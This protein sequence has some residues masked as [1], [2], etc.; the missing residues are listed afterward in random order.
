MTTSAGSDVRAFLAIEL[1]Q[2]ALVRVG[3]VQQIVRDAL[4]D[5]AYVR[6]NMVHI[7]LKFLGNVPATLVPEIERLAAPAVG[8]YRPFRVVISGLG[9]FP[10]ADSPRVIWLGITGDVTPLS[11]LAV[12][13]DEALARLNL[14]R[15]ARA[16]SPHLTLARVRRRLSRSELVSLGNV[17]H[18]L[19]EVRIE[20]V[21]THVSLM[22][23]HLQRGGAVYERLATFPLR[24]GHG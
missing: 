5:L 11:K 24:D 14:P 19:R 9:V 13:L 4:P 16:F 22:R 2:D 7:T 20:F 23:S 3:Q 12:S 8:G 21:V 15:E 1:P 6:P 10:S 18:R 17:A